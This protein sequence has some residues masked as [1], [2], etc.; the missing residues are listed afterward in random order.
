MGLITLDLDVSEF[1]TTE[2][3]PDELEVDMSR[4]L[5]KKWGIR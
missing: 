2:Y 1:F 5:K 3:L 4:D